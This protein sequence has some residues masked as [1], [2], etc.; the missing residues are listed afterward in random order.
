MY[1]I[2][3]YEIYGIV[4][5]TDVVALNFN[6][7][8]PTHTFTPITQRNTLHRVSEKNSQ[9]CFRQNFVKFPLT[10]IIFG[11]KMAKALEMCT[12]H[13]FSTSPSLC[14]RTTM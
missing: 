2:D 14:Q 9:N 7:H 13:S 4:I 10:L 6:A 1:L 5:S 8:C 12:V 3:S 11:T